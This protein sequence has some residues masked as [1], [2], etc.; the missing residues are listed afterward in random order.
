LPGLQHV[1]RFVQLIVFVLLLQFALL[2]GARGAAVIIGQHRVL[3]GVRHQ[4][5]GRN[6]R[7][8]N[9]LAA[10]RVVLG[11]GKNERGAV[12]NLDQLLH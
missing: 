12:G 5:V 9:G 7:V 11:N 1:N 4:D 8:L 3:V 6:R 2:V 10:G